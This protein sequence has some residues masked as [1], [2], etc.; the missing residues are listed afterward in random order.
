[1]RRA[2]PARSA[3]VATRDHETVEYL[4]ATPDI[5]R[6]RGFRTSQGI[7]AGSSREDALRAYGNPT[8]YNI[9]F[10]VDGAPWPIRA[11]LIY[12][13]IGPVS[14]SLMGLSKAPSRQPQPP[15]ARICDISEPGS[16]TA[17]TGSGG[18]ERWGIQATINNMGGVPCQ[19]GGSPD[20]KP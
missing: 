2:P 18:V 8:A 9:L 7:A 4:Y 12:D 13:N 1:M 6:G 15:P 5:S 17:G 19:G 16:R 3:S 10:T 11:R 20:G 14:P